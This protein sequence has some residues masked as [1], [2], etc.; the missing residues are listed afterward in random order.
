M[1]TFHAPYITV[2][3]FFFLVLLTGGCIGGLLRATLNGKS[4]ELL[5]SFGVLLPTVIGLISMLF[6]MD[7][8][9]FAESLLSM[10]SQ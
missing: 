6:L 8:I 10:A 9:R 3:T 1:I 7:Q 5:I 2:L 4:N